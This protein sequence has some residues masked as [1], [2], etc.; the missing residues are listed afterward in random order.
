MFQSSLT[1]S[2]VA[3]GV[4]RLLQRMDVA[5]LRE[6]SLG[7]GRRADV[8][9]LCP[10]GDITL[11]EIKISLADLRSDAKWETYLAYCDLFFFA[12][13]S[14]FPLEALSADPRV[15][16]IMADAHDAVILRQGMRT[17]LS[18]SRRRA[19]TIR[20]ARKA[21]GRLMLTLDP[22]LGERGWH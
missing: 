21:A 6:F 8:A 9:G 18:G 5:S 17:P 20:F 4:G 12:V 1:A 2:D 19:E 16:V 7:S 22:G 15:G 10:K 13:P 11:V 14:G 3:R